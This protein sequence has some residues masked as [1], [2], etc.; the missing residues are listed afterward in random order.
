M[1]SSSLPSSS[2]SPTSHLHATNSLASVVMEAL[3]NATSSYTIS[4]SDSRRSSSS[5]SILGF[6]DDPR[7]IAGQ[8]LGLESGSDPSDGYMIS[9]TFD[10]SLAGI[11][12]GDGGPSDNFGGGDPDDPMTWG[13]TTIMVL[14]ILVVSVI[15]FAAIFGNLL[16]MISV[17]RHYKLRTTTNYFIVSLACADILVAA[18]AMTFNASVA[19]TGRWIFNRVICDF[20]NSCD[21]LF[22]TASIM[23]L[24]CISLDRYYA[25]IKPLDYPMKITARTVAYMLAVVW[26]S[27]SLISFVPIFTGWYT[28]EEHLRNL[29]RHPDMCEF[30]VN[31]PYALI[32]SSVSFWL[33][34]T[35]MLFTYWKIYMEATKQ[36]K[37][38]QRSQVMPQA[39]HR[40]KTDQNQQNQRKLRAN[41]TDGKDQISVHSA[42]TTPQPGGPVGGQHP[43][44]RNSHTGGPDD[45]ESGQSTP[46]KRSINKMKREHK[47]AKTLGIIMGAFIACW[48]PFFIG[49]VTLT[50]CDV[51]KD[52][53][54]PIV[55][56][57]LFWIGYFNSSLN[58]IIYAYFNRE[59]REA[60]KE[61]IQNV[62]CRCLQMDCL[63]TRRHHS[64]RGQ[65]APTSQNAVNATNYSTTTTMYKSS[66]DRTSAMREENFGLVENKYVVVMTEELNGSPDSDINCLTAQTEECMTHNNNHRYRSWVAL[67]I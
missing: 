37:F 42:A 29:E 14:K 35:V 49:Y 39:H 30:V 26:V 22:S 38:M 33:P 21:V 2:S 1:L 55:V 12:V 31:T 60:F 47:A 6:D 59:F 13:A 46:T 52:K 44:P 51:C 10:N 58:P 18:F 32:S 19:I 57:I 7:G 64:G 23:H 56:D 3:H 20:W 28:T 25:I 67:R 43:L 15:I 9:S 4:T 63:Q 36:E 11:P 65:Y 50:V 61:T 8:S 27:S 34:C 66:A 17:A 5:S 48:L 54:P 24:C 53:T 16:V 62:F 40:P 41:S 45:P